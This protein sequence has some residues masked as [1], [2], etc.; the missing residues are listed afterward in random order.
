MGDRNREARRGG[1]GSE[2]RRLLKKGKR[3]ILNVIFGRTML[4]VLTLAL[5]IGLL[6]AIFSSLQSV[7]G[8]LPVYYALLLLLYGGTILHLVNKRSEPTTKITWILLVVLA[9]P[10]GLALYLFVELDIGHRVLNRRLGELMEETEALLP[11]RMP[12]PEGA[13]EAAEELEGLA[14]YTWAHGRYPLYG[15]TAARYLSSGEASLEAMLEDLRAAKDFIFLEFFIIEEG[16]MWGRVLKVLEDKVAEGVEVR[17]MY[18]GTCALFRLPYRYPEMLKKLGIQCKMFS[19]I[20]PVISAHYNNRDHRK[21]L[22]VDGRVAYTGGVNLADEYVNRISPFGHWKDVSLRLEGPAVRAFTLMFLQMWNVDETGD[23]YAHYMTAPVSAPASASGWVLPYGDS[24]VDNERVGELVYTDIL[25]R[26]RRYV[27]IMTPYLILDSE[28]ISA[29]TFAAKRGVEVCVLLPHIPDKRYAFALAKTHYAEL[30]QAGV[31]I[32]EYTPGFVH[33][34]VFVSDDC[35]AVVGTVNLDYRSFYLHF[36]CAAYLRDMPAVADVEA[37]FQATLA[38]SREVTPEDLKRIP[39]TT[40]LAGW[41]LK[42][43]APVM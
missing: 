4:V 41:L 28:M 36:E 35:K 14:R 19:P 13:F 5:Q 16:Y 34:K 22:V 20:R 6:V 43:V 18:D 32:F 40:R 21:I 38:R 12:A 29:L 8:I 15:G 3:G 7:Q 24:P 9:P 10:V 37:D 23:R 30:M 33:A 17:L 25:S 2:E 39:L 1:Q 27:H 11:E 31:R 26:A 42:V